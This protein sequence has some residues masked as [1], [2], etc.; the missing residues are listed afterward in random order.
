MHRTKF[1]AFRARFNL[2]AKDGNTQ[3]HIYKVTHKFWIILKQKSK[4]EG[5][6]FVHL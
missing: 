3:A 5:K 4:R 1:A 2:C 6:I